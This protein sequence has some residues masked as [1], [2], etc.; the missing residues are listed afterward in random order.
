LEKADKLFEHVTRIVPLKN[1]TFKILDQEVHKKTI[2]SLNTTDVLFILYM[3]KQ[4]QHSYTSRSSTTFQY[5]VSQDCLPRPA[6]QGSKRCSFP[7]L[8][9]IQQHLEA[10]IRNH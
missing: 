2:Y 8:F 1:L 10:L 3:R 4:F 9:C 6:T 7:W 5:P